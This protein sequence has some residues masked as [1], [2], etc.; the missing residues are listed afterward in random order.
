MSNDLLGISI[1]NISHILYDNLSINLE[2][3]LITKLPTSFVLNLLNDPRQAPIYEVI[4]KF[5]WSLITVKDF[6]CNKLNS[7]S[8][9]YKHLSSPIKLG[10][11]SLKN[12]VVLAAMTRMRTDPKTGIPNDLMVDYYSQRAGAGLILTECAAVSQRGEGFPGAGNF[13][14]KQQADGWKRVVAAVKAKGAHIFAQ[15]F[16]AGRNS[17]PLMNGNQ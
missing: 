9:M 17:H 6:S 4:S 2:L 8:E 14:N 16:H 13:Y 7:L 1:Y 15:L 12:R 10:T 5:R 11:L 3:R